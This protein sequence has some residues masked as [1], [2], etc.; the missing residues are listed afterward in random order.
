MPEY[1]IA[2]LLYLAAATAAMGWRGL[3]RDRR[4]WIALAA[5][6]FMT[7]AFDLVLTGLPIVTYGDALRSGIAIGPMP[8]E[9]LLYGMALAMTALIAADFASGRGG[10]AVGRTHEGPRR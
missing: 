6:G 7:V 5:F 2:S 1:T 8:I 3:F 10:H 4:V 9:D